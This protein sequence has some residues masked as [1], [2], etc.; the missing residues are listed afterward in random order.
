MVFE[1]LAQ[2]FNICCSVIHTEGFIVFEYG[3]QRLCDG[4]GVGIPYDVGATIVRNGISDNEYSIKKC[5]K[6]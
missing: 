6:L 5:S 1:S 4:I 2:T 3:F